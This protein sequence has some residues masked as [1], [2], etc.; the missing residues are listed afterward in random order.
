MK[1]LSDYMN[2]KQEILFK[3]LGIIFAFDLDTLNAKRKKGFGMF[4]PKPNR[5][6][7]GKRY[8]QIHIMKENEESLR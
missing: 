7:F 2:P 5:E 4:C 6:E 8:N 1:F 3:E